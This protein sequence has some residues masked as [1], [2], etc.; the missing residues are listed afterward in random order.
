MANHPAR[1]R[2]QERLS[3]RASI[4]EAGATSSSASAAPS[5]AAAAPEASAA[6]APSFPKVFD[7]ELLSNGWSAPPEDQMSVV[8]RY[9]FQIR[10]TQN[11]PN[12]AAGFLPVY[13]Y[14]RYVAHTF[15]CYANSSHG[16][17]N[18]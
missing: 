5:L 7:P 9:P 4:S 17:P 6:P 1:L 16:R 18:P 15:S 11:K 13:T 2:V 10:R 8:R 14:F 3:N 12:D